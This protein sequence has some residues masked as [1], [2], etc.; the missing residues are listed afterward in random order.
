M[1]LESVLL[2][3]ATA[4]PSAAALRSSTATSSSE[5]SSKPVVRM[6]ASA[7]S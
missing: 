4:R 5:V 7:G 1:A 2:M 3:S 6:F